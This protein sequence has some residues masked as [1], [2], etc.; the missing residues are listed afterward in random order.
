MKQAEYI[1]IKPQNVHKSLIPP[2]LMQT[3]AVQV[4]DNSFILSHQSIFNAE[5]G[6]YDE[7]TNTLTHKQCFENETTETKDFENKIYRKIRFE[8]QPR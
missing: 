7:I 3:V 1:L 4:D 6:T 5:D 2:Q 8:V